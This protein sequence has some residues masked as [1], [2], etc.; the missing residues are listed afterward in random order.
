MQIKIMYGA[1]TCILVFLQI[2][3][4]SLVVG[5]HSMAWKLRS[6]QIAAKDAQFT[7]EDIRTRAVDLRKDLKQLAGVCCKFLLSGSGTLE[8]KDV[9]VR[10]L[11]DVLQNFCPLATGVVGIDE[12]ILEIEESL[13]KVLVRFIE[14]NIFDCGGNV[15]SKFAIRTA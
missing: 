11:C 15:T 8:C 12:V 10:V 14:E 2:I 5:Y 1:G 7:A 3:Q 13:V 6:L 4:R 9:G